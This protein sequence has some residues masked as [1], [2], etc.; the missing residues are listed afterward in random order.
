MGI[1]GDERKVTV[2]TWAVS[3]SALPLP[4]G[5]GNSPKLFH[6]KAARD[7]IGLIANA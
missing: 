4:K 1:T 2:K 3:S 5:G 6:S 7:R